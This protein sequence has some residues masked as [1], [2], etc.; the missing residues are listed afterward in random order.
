[1]VG[2]RADQRDLRLPD[3]LCSAETEFHTGWFVESLATK[4]PVLFVIRTLAQSVA[5]PAQFGS[6]RDDL[7]IALIG[8]VLPYSPVCGRAG[9]HEVAGQYFAFL[10]PATVTYLALVEIVKRRLLP[11]PTRTAASTRAVMVPHHLLLSAF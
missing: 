3:L 8:L 2:H 4:T 11:Q 5:E 9:I 10:G 1:M 6:D 7:A